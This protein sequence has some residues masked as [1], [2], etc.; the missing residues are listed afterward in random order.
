MKKNSMITFCIA[1]TFLFISSMPCFALIALPQDAGI[2]YK[3]MKVTDAA[4]LKARGMKKAET[5]DSVTFGPVE[6][7]GVSVTNKRTGE[8][9][10]WNYSK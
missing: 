3:T 6:G 4:K 1:I 10:K 5:G 7:G 8:K 9:I 2:D